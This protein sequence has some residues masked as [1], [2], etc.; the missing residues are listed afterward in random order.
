VT[1]R[2]LPP[3]EWARLAGTELETVW[4]HLHAASAQIV[5][6][7]QD[8]Q[9]VGCWALMRVVHVEGVWIAPA[10]RGKASVAKRLLQGMRRAAAQWGAKTVATAALTD[11]VRRLV[12]HLGGVALPG[13]H[14]VMSVGGET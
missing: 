10:Y 2:L 13:E 9:I 4:P 7:E 8:G 14:F 1:T 12:A 6:V 5:V 3:E 11:D